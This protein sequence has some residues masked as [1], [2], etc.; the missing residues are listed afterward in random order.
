VEILILAALV[1]WQ[2]AE[3]DAA[4]FLKLFCHAVVPSHFS[5]SQHFWLPTF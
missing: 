3:D 2:A 5:V 1:P 4:V